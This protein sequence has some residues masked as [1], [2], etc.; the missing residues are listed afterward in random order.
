MSVVN[1]LEIVTGEGDHTFSFFRQSKKRK[2]SYPHQLTGGKMMRKTYYSVAAAG[3]V[4]LLS[5]QQSAMACCDEEPEVIVIEGYS[6]ITK[7]GESFSFSESELPQ[8]NEGTQATLKIWAKGDFS[9]GN[10]DEYLS[11]DIEG[12]QDLGGPENGGEISEE[13]D[14]SR[15]GG[16]WFRPNKEYNQTTWSQAWT[17][18]AGDMASIL[19][20]GQLCLTIDLSDEVNI[21][22]RAW[23]GEF[24]QAGD[25]I[26]FELSYE[27]GGCVDPEPEPY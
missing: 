2:R 14:W 11:W 23:W 19:S 15:D 12:V 7:A 17:I 16:T 13:K 18:D 1:E 24:G 26:F 27:T 22:H 3:L 25:S 4:L 8:I 6:T 9:A 10:I 20:D 21:I 5:V